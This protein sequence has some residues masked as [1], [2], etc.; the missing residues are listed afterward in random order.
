MSNLAPVADAAGTAHDVAN[1]AAPT[2]LTV[3][4]LKAALKTRGLPSVGRKAEL[5]AMLTAVLES[6][7]A[8]PELRADKEI[9]LAAVR[10]S[11]AALEHA[12]RALR[13]DKEVVIDRITATATQAQWFRCRFRRRT[14]VRV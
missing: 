4:Q 8:A 3:K 9:V 6:E 1:S 11:G 10:T 7:A 5:V 2:G 12:A 13:R 14:A